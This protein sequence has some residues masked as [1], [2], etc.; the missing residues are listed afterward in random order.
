MVTFFFFLNLSI[1]KRLKI[2]WECPSFVTCG[3]AHGDSQ[4]LK[5]GL[6]SVVIY[7]VKSRFT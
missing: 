4:V 3:G 2:V 1:Y 7:L 6:I 5:S